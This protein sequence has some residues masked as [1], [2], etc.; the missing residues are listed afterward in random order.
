MLVNFS[1]G[2]F[3]SF[4]EIQTLNLVPEGLKDLDGNLHIPY[5]YN[6]KGFQ[7]FQKFVF[8]SFSYGQINNTIDVQPFLLNTS[9]Y[10]KPSFFEITFLI[11]ETKYR[12]RFALNS[13][14]IFEEELHY[15][16]LKIRENYLFKRSGQDIIIS[17]TWNKES[18]NKL[19]QAIYFTKPHILFLSV[20]LSQENIP[21]ILSI[22]NWLSA[23]L[24]IPDD[25]IKE[26][27]KARTI[28]S[29]PTYKSLIMKF[30]KNADLGFT[31]I[32]DKVENMSNS[33]LQLEKGLLNMWF[34]K[35]IKNYDLY[36]SHNIFNLDKAIVE[37]IE[38]ELQKNESSGSIKYFI[39]TSLI[40]FRNVNSIISQSGDKSHEFSNDLHNS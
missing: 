35:E 9:M 24:V 11:K 29:D 37:N 8:N 27:M 12:Y 34:D 36:T 7:F 3:L 38:F 21:K 19:N 13:K 28:Y 18:D 2:N 25:Y 14:E 5:L 40:T 10:N 17:K 22:S 20:L 4:K 6:I 33:K 1:L 15:S 23:N 26:L 30:I 39:I 32:F 31:T 16:E